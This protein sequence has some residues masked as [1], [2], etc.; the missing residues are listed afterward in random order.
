[1]GGG[2]EPGRILGS[3]IWVV[4]GDG[5]WSSARPSFQLQAQTP[6]AGRLSQSGEVAKEQVAG[7]QASGPG[8][9]AQLLPFPLQHLNW[10][11]KELLSQSLAEKLVSLLPAASLGIAAPDLGFLSNVS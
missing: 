11:G 1:M 9:P 8:W 5:G 10:A 4:C 2:S 3:C 6:L 7:F